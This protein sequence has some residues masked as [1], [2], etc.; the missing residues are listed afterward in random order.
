MHK[1][2]SGNEN[3]TFTLTSEKNLFLLKIVDGVVNTEIRFLTFST[4]LIIICQAQI[5]IN[6]GKSLKEP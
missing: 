4:S 6:R 2:N 1:H 5:A 3:E